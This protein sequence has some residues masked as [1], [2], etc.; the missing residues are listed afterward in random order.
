MIPFTDALL[1]ELDTRLRKMLAETREP[2]VYAEAAVKIIVPILQELKGFVLEYRF[3]DK[4]EEVLFFKVIKPR[5]VHQLI[6]YNEIYGIESNLPLGGEKAVRKYLRG[7]LDK[8]KVFF[9]CNIEFFR[10]HRTGSGYLDKKYFVRG[11]HCFRFSADSYYYEAD[12]RFCT[13]HD[14]K[15][16]KIIANDLLQVYLERRL[17]E[18]DGKADAPGVNKGVSLKW[19]GS[20]VNLVE[21]VFALHA[22]GVFNNGK[23]D[24]KETVGFFEEAFGVD[25]G[26]FHRTFYEMRARKSER[27]RFLNSLRET[28]VRRMDEVDE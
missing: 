28:L 12:H 3:R 18:L 10:Y 2:I 14:F 7:E 5:F 6:Y 11:K 20:K 8:L 26:Q 19:T 15:V 9:D 13:S 24:L 16:A 23:S 22:E 1:S 21:M 17:L 27:T 4:A 25:L